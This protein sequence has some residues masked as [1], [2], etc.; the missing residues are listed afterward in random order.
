MFDNFVENILK[1]S[2]SYTVIWF[3]ALYSTA[4]RQTVVGM[5]GTMYRIIILV[6]HKKAWFDNKMDGSTQKSPARHKN[7]QTQKC[8]TQ[9]ALVDIDIIEHPP[10]PPPLFLLK[11]FS[12]FNQTFCFKEPIHKSFKNTAVKTVQQRTSLWPGFTM[13]S[14]RTW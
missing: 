14:T 9:H 10:P 12:N 3:E 7:A 13:H 4:F 1:T 8:L 6:W 11:L 5:H 2:F